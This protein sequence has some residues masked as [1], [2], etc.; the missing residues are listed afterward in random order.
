VASALLALGLTLPA[1][2]IAAV[3]TAAT[4]ACGH[5][6]ALTEAG[7]GWLMMRP[8]FSNP[9][10][11][12][13]AYA[14]PPYDPNLIWATD[15]QQIV[16]TEDAGC[17]WTIVYTATDPHDNLPQLPTL[18]QPLPSAPAL[19]GVQI[20]AL[21]APSSANQ[22]AYLYVG[23]TS[24][25]A[26]VPQP[27]IVTTSNRGKTW[28]ATMGDAKGGLPLVGTVN[29]ITANANVPQIAYALVDTGVSGEPRPAMFGTT[30]GGVTWTRRTQDT[31]TA[32][33]TGLHA[34]PLL[35]SNIYGL[36]GQHLEV[37][38]DGSSTWAAVGS[39]SAAVTAVDISSASG[40]A[41]IA[42]PLRDSAGVAV[43]HDDGRSWSTV[44]APARLVSVAGAPLQEMFA[45]T[46]GKRLWFLTGASHISPV[47]PTGS[48]P[49]SLTVS[50]PTAVGF[51]VTGVRGGAMFRATYSLDR[52]IR[53]PQVVNGKVTPVYI[54]PPGPITQFPSTLAPMTTTLQLPVGGHA[55]V[56]Y[57][58]L[59]PRTPTPVDLM[60]LI[61]TTNSMQPV[62]DGLR[63][64]LA[65]IATSLDTAGLNA[66]FGLGDFRDYPS[67]WGSGRTIDYPYRLD[68]PV[69][70][71]GSGL[72]DA[73]ASMTATGNTRDGDESALTALV[74]SST[75]AGDREQ[76]QT[77]VKPG[78]EAGYRAD[79][80]RLAMVA[81]DTPPHYGGEL[82]LNQKDQNPVPNPGPGFA[83]AIAA[84]RAHDVHQVGL[85]IE[86]ASGP[87]SKPALTQLAAATG[88]LA[89]PGG[90]DCNGDGR[91]DVPTGIPLVCTVGSEK[92]STVSVGSSGNAVTAASMAAAV[93]SLAANYPDIRPVQLQ[94]NSGA[95]YVSVLSAPQLV[96]LHADNQ[97]SYD[98]DVRCPVGSGGVHPIE[99]AAATPMRTVA[100][101]A[102]DL[103][104]LAKGTLPPVATGGVVAP[105]VA[106]VAGPAPGAPA[107]PNPG[108]NPNPN[109]N[110]NPAPNPMTGIVDQQQDQP[111][112]AFA[113]ADGITND[114]EQL[115]MSRL[116]IGAAAALFAVSCSVV[117]VRRRRTV[118]ARADSMS[119]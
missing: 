93:I 54:V 47:G 74:Q 38:S 26:G 13:K 20:T 82:V 16:R 110:P 23:V 92:Q 100:T 65:Q 57:D 96:N 84:M 99:L 75:G 53:R 98:V 103:T 22:S 111:Q 88:A 32:P 1:V 61:D 14:S 7:N 86:P 72:A 48:S 104:C 87:S 35:T 42:A 31:D 76:G 11:L 109:P 105:V 101:A 58:L 45:G 60:F 15:G 90:V 91:I 115:A 9:S 51:A 39:L 33:A 21:T 102:I 117:A 49:V 59:L 17:N 10:A 112:L 19:S 8:T 41:R 63:Q 78:Q 77:F 89:P 73:L 40:K 55:R 67:P 113:G 97:L 52:Q 4:A 24:T 43:T 118:C 12:V 50:A 25:L 68:R 5:G 79:A 108:P 30:D 6:G 81:T 71:A 69:G 80:L 46:D 114:D 64:A 44:P 62:I 106:V 18:P 37:S 107:P 27:E 70:P 95:A 66:H 85:A 2:G 36:S 119:A 94:P 116:S 3:P 34:H 29:E 28:T 56:H 83:D